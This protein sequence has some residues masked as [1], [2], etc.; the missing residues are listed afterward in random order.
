V[1]AELLPVSVY[2]RPGQELTAS[3]VGHGDVAGADLVIKRY[4]TCAQGKGSDWTQVLLRLAAAAWRR[5]SSKEPR[6]WSKGPS[7]AS[8]LQQVVAHMAARQ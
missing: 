6:V 8:V 5:R 7:K 3:R 1:Q 2:Q 4:L